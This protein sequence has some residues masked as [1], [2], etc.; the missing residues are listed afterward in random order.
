VSVYGHILVEISLEIMDASLKK[1]PPEA[2]K[3]LRTCPISTVS[4]Y[5]L[6][7]APVYVFMKLNEKYVAVKAALDFFTPGELER[8]KPFETFFIPDSIDRTLP[9]RDAG[10]RVRGLLTYVPPAPPGQ[11]ERLSDFPEVALPPAPY[12]MSDAVLRV[13]GPLWEL[14]PGS[15]AAIEPYFLLAL[16]N[17]LCEVIPGEM[18]SKARDFDVKLYETAVYRSSWAVFMALHLGY[19]DLSFLNALRMRVFQETVKIIEPEQALRSE[20]DDL[21]A[22]ATES[23]ANER[24]EKVGEGSFTTRSDRSSQKLLARINRVKALR[25][26]PNV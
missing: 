20:I 13:L 23:L 8:L 24:V 7:L 14:V 1:L 12:E 4:P 21:V 18:L 16:V 2:E 3:N 26:G 9:Y 11:D 10:R 25:E 19:C 17:E 5:V 22:I 15:G 6:M